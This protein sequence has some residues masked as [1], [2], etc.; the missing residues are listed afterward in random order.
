MCVCVCCCC[1]CFKFAFFLLFQFQLFK[2]MDMKFERPLKF[3]LLSFAQTGLCCSLWFIKLKRNT[4]G[5][6]VCVWA[7]TCVWERE[8]VCVCL[9]VCVCERERERERVFCLNDYWIA[10]YS[11]TSRG[12][13]FHATEY[14]KP[15]QPYGLYQDK[16]K[17]YSGGD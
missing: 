6:C 17:I 9:C 8:C 3:L 2:I 13:Q 7:C 1:V 12:G 5:V 4:I 16:T 14:V 11:S 15:C 10:A